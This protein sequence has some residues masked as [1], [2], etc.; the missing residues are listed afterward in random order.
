M[1]ISGKQLFVQGGSG[2]LFADYVVSD[3]NKY[4][5]NFITTLTGPAGGFVNDTYQ[6][7]KGTF[8]DIVA[9]DQE[10]LLGNAAGF[11]KKQA[12]DPWPVQ[13]FTN[14]MWDSARLMAD[15]SY[16]GTMNRIRR[17]RKAEFGQDYW[18]E[19]AISDL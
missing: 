19:Q 10:H 2:S 17:K 16:Q 7:T 9:G 4:G 1:P 5:G 18:W 13:L 15:P 6:L 12:P 11:L 3:V 8:N 14:Y